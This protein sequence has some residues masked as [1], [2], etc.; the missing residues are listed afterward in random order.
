MLTIAG[1][2]DF[3][4]LAERPQRPRPG[5]RLHW[6]GRS[7]E[8]AGHVS[9]TAMTDLPIISMPITRLPC[10]ALL[11]RVSQRAWLAF[12][13]LTFFF[14]AEV[15]GR[16]SG[17]FPFTTSKTRLSGR[18]AKSGFTSRLNCMV[19]GCPSS[20][21]KRAAFTSVESRRTARLRNA[22]IHWRGSECTDRR[23]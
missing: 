21:R 17:R 2:I 22:D 11:I 5:C 4:S 12:R 15:Q 3:A 16:R 9:R 14:L 19:V 6:C 23:G 1:R 13:K 18:S 20:C 10:M 8:S 7:G